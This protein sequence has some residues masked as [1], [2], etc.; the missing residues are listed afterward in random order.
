MRLLDTLGALPILA[1]YG[2]ILTVT[3]LVLLPLFLRLFILPRGFSIGH[4]SLTAIHN[5]RWLAPAPAGNPTARPEER[6]SVDVKKI[7]FARWGG[8]GPLAKAAAKVTR[9]KQPS[10][11]FVLRLDGVRVRVPKAFA[12]TPRPPKKAP[13][14]TRS[15]SASPPTSPSPSSRR[16]SISADSADADA[17]SRARASHPTFLH[18]LGRRLSC[19]FTL[20]AIQISFTVEVEDVAVIAG[21]ISAGGEVQHPAGSP[22]SGKEDDRESLAKA[23]VRLER[24]EVREMPRGLDRKFDGGS[25]NGA[26]TPLPA[27]E[28]PEGVVFKVE[29]PLVPPSS[30]T[31]GEGSNRWTVRPG[32][33]KVEIEFGGEEP[34][35]IAKGAVR[36]AKG[37]RREMKE[38]VKAA[39]AKTREKV[40]EKARGGAG[41]GETAPAGV[42]V[43]VHELKRVL[44]SIE[45]IALQRERQEARSAAEKGEPEERGR[46]PRAP[47][48]RTASAPYPPPSSKPPPLALLKSVSI[49]LPAFILS[50]HYTTP[51]HVVAASS[52]S[53][54]RSLPETMAFAF[55]IRGAKAEVR[56]G[57]ASDAER[58]RKEHREWLGKGRE[59]ACAAKLEWKELEGRV[60]LDGDEGEVLRNASKTLSIGPS[61]L[62]LTSTWLPSPLARA[63][64]P[65]PLHSLFGNPA[66]VDHSD[67]LLILEGFLGA[68]RGHVPF[69]TLDA[70]LR[71]FEARPRPV[72]ASR[73]RSNSAASEASTSPV[74]PASPTSPT[75]PTSPS[76]ASSDA[77]PK[78]PPQPTRASRPMKVHGL[79]RL[80]GN[81][82]SAGIEL[83]VQA[84]VPAASAVGSVHSPDPT[85]SPA[86]NG[87]P[88]DPFFRTWASPELLCVSLPR[89][90]IT[91]GGEYRER[92]VKRSEADRRAARRAAKHRRAES[93]ASARSASSSVRGGWDDEDDADERGGRGRS[94]STGRRGERDD[95]EVPVSPTK[96]FEDEFGVP[97][98][99]PIS[100][101]YGK[102]R[103]VPPRIPANLTKDLDTFGLEYS[104]HVR[105]SAET[106]NVY[107]LASNHGEHEDADYTDSEDG[108]DHDRHAMPALPSDPVRLDV[109]AIGP[110]EVSSSVK[111]LGDETHEPVKGFVPFVDL[112]ECS[113]DHAIL[114]ETI[115][116]DLWRPVVRGCIRDFLSSFAS[117]SSTATARRRAAS[118]APPP[119][120]PPARPPVALPLVDVLPQ[121]Q[122]IY[123]SLAAFD[124]RIAGTDP[125]A[126]E[127]ACRGIAAHSGPL[128]LEYLLQGSH[129]S[130][131]TGNFAERSA[132]DL[133]EDI[134]VEA[135]S[136]INPHA[137]HGRAAAPPPEKS[138]LFKLSLN[139]W[140]VDPV[141]DARASRGQR[142]SM[143]RGDGEGEEDGDDWELR[144]RAEMAEQSKRRKSIIPPRYD[145]RTAG[146]G[147]EKQ[148]ASS[149]VVIPHLALRVKVQRAPP[150][151]Y[152]QDSGDEPAS[153]SPIDEIIVNIESEVV[154]FRL[155]LFSI[156][157][158]LVAISSLRSL[159][160]KVQ[161]TSADKHRPPSRRPVRPPPLVRVRADIADVHAFP[162]L[163]HDTHL[164]LNL[165]R[166]RLNHSKELG[167]VCEFDSALLAGESPTVPDKWEDIIRLQQISLGVRPEP[168]NDG[169]QPFVV[170]LSAET[171]RLRIPF[172]Y[173]FSRII[174]NTANLI[175]ATKQLVHEHIKGGQG[176]ILEPAPEEAKRLPKID[177]NI[178]LLAVSFQDDPFETKLNIIWRAGYEEQSARLDRE[179]AFDNKVEAIR[180]RDAN[181]GEEEDDA[182]GTDDEES[183]FASRQTPKVD[184]RHSISVEEARRDLLAYNSSHWIKRIRNA[185]AEQAR[186]EEALT[187]QLYGAK[188]QNLRPDSRLPIELVPAS[189]S[190]PLARATFHRLSLVL[191]KPSFGDEG[192][193]DY[194]HDVGKG[195]PRD[196]QFT[197]LVP[198]HISC[199]MREA[200]FRLRDYP[201]PLLHV[202]PG[203]DPDHASWE[204]EA[205]LVIAEEVGGPESVR[206]V[207]C[208]VIPQHVFRGQGAPYSIVVPRSAMTVKTY[209]TPTITI[210]TEEPTRIGW[211]NSVQPAIQDLARV[212]DTL[213]K[214]S[215]DPSDRIG[216]WDKIRLQLHW[217]V[218]FRFEGPRASVIFHLKGSR[219][220]YALTGFGAGFAKAWKGNVQFR[221]GFDNPDHEFF[222]VLSEEYILGIP[223]LRDY[224]DAAATG[225]LAREVGADEDD[226][227]ARG[228]SI[229]ETYEGQSDNASVNDS[230]VDEE[231][232][233]WIKICAK[234][235]NGVRW[236]LGLKCE[237]TCRDECSKPGCRDQS[238][239]HRQCR[240]FDFI[241]H[242][243]V[244]T[245]TR[246]SIGPH[247]EVDDSFAGF[248]SDFVH[249]SISLT[250]PAT[251]DLP[252]RDGSSPDASA[253]YGGEHG[254]NSFHFTP[255]ANAHFARWWKTFD[256]TMSL[257]IRQGKL[258]PSAQAPSKKF[259]KH[260][261]TIKYRFSLAPLF[262]SHTYRQD[263][264]AEWGRGETT[265]LG[266]KGKI[267]R[268][269]VD[270]HQR[271]QEMSIRRPEM[272]ESKTVKHKA[273]YMAEI[274]LD[275]VDLRT[276]TALFQEPEKAYVAPV[277]GD[278]E[279]DATPP[280]SF[281]NFHV[282]DEDADWINLNDFNDA[283]Y[284]MA[285]RRPQLRLLPLM[286]CPRFTY[287]RHTDAA[288]VREGDDTSSDHVELM[289][290]DRGKTKFGHEGSHTCLMGCA[291]DTIGVQVKEAEM[292][293]AELELDMAPDQARAD[294]LNLRIRAVQ[295]IIERLERVR[296]ETQDSSRVDGDA[297]SPKQSSYGRSP[298]T[299]ASAYQP[300]PED[301][302]DPS[303]LPHLA[304]T[305]HE[306]WGNWENRYMVHN[307]TI[308]VSNATREV[309]LK[310]YY[311]SRDRK[312]H[313]YHV[314][315][316][317]IRFIR[318]LVKQHEHKY[319]RNMSRRKSTRV[320]GH[321]K[322]PTWDD[323]DAKNRLLDDLINREG[324]FWAKN[325]TEDG[326]EGW[327]RF[328][329]H[330]DVDPE[331]ASAALP[332]AF[333]ARTGHLCMFIKPQISLQSD[334]DEKSTLIITA[335]RAQLKVFEIVDTRILDDP[336][337]AEVLHQTFARLDGLQVFYPRQQGAFDDGRAHAFVPLETLVDLRVEP[338]G[339]DR[340]VPR[341][342]AAFRYD[343]FNQLRLSSKRSLGD[344]GLGPTSTL[345]SH[346]HTA[347]DRMSI[348]CEKF[349]LSA[350]PA[351]FAAIY[352][353]VT[354]LILYSDPG[355]KSRSTKLEA[356]VF[357]RD[358][359][360]L[361]S[362]IET[363]LTLQQRLR[364][365]SAL[366]QE[367]HVHLDELDD[368][369]RVEL[370]VVRADYVRLSAELGLVV[371]ALTRAQDSNGPK[372]TSKGPGTQL[373]ARAAEITWHMLDKTDLPFA[374]FSVI[375]AEF[376]WI[377][378]QD[379]SASNRLVVKDLRALNSS[380]DQIFAEIIAKHDVPDT[381]NEL[382]KVDV[383]AAALWNSLAPVG[384][385]SIVERFELH[386]HP[387]RLQLE[388]RIG[389][390]IVEY[391]FTEREQKSDEEEG[392]KPS[393]PLVPPASNSQA[394]RSVDSLAL[395]RGG[396]SQSTGALTSSSASIHSVEHRLRKTVSAE[397]LAP[398]AAEEGLDADE[399][400]RR[401]AAYRTFIF[402]E[403]SSTVLCLTY[404]SEKE[405]KSSLPNIYNITYKTPAIQYRSRT[406]SFLEL[407]NE[408]K[409]D[410][411]RSVWQQKGQLLGQLLSKAHRSLPLTDVRSAAKQRAVSAVRSRFSRHRDGSKRD[412]PLLAPP[413]SVTPSPPPSY[414]TRRRSDSSSSSGEEDE[415]LPFDIGAAELINPEV[416]DR[417]ASV[418]VSS[419]EAPFAAEPDEMSMFSGKG[420]GTATSASRSATMQSTASS[421]RQPS[422]RSQDSHSSSHHSH[423][424]IPSP[425]Y[426]HHEPIR[427]G[428]VQ[429][430]DDEKRRM[431][432]GKSA[433]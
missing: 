167:V 317:V 84:P 101:D 383:F 145:P 98:P 292:R 205:D 216:F 356:L 178:G 268:F 344:H 66:P 378:K 318:D 140:S 19:L 85:A 29:A 51:L 249:F 428:T 261:A 48:I 110:L 309:L 302:G 392:N 36:A 338:W 245:K 256:G 222:Q 371:E 150:V 162:T 255:H 153:P 120:S 77:P 106:L 324:S 152:E 258:F 422:E 380:P 151:A 44:R 181:G 372:T 149:L 381:D 424:A 214:P 144:G 123:V 52:L 210:R 343:K 213:S 419:T 126:D 186:R 12:L 104:T 267:G 81:F 203:H 71:I 112:S 83:R 272:S 367:Y 340:V 13:S 3:L 138:A 193:A 304:T 129:D 257:P 108:W 103:M 128:V 208:A 38:R 88:T 315:A 298:P 369:G 326:G 111:F 394:S 412:D 308:R 328:G 251:L 395:P 15:P 41:E 155:E 148:A 226:R 348:E 187:R 417:P 250:S 342:S 17:S 156:Y 310:Y 217:R 399:M 421:S 57:G 99:P 349:S 172:R 384:G 39:Q 331:S 235:I 294:E 95:D 339:F 137:T 312:G 58:V 75:S 154:T 404:R 174:D 330:L 215:P 347:T 182:G 11:W 252:G 289:P 132:L 313:V 429:L 195:F 68:V 142:R 171:A 211:G 18:R 141:V 385:I 28:M 76:S 69:E 293:L 224:V 93:K 72:G 299:P 160:P 322:N 281:D 31:S 49:S 243:Q 297:D 239:F 133:R 225:A 401:A 332:E 370:A 163:P 229:A 377:S 237:R 244:H 430:R 127:H 374:K 282:A 386:L 206:R 105:F 278:A 26:S 176:F 158:A 63:A 376:S 117:A 295:H 24:L 325:E 25:T 291:T 143:R 427:R 393:S 94:R 204:C 42:H 359:S 354:D 373:E 352:N 368:E 16:S 139:E 118:D 413:A 327:H 122:C 301:S 89:G 37:V 180:R 316:S 200:R 360:N 305:L 220:P 355:R 79:P 21:V 202:P 161:S 259:G 196:T 402:V 400:R 323:S 390:Q 59:L 198:L 406:W 9:K 10:A 362:V 136:N 91:F 56:M 82:A 121:D 410:T 227:S 169:Q 146:K 179:T 247:G 423:H 426:P 431:L 409:R 280:P 236:G 109:L 240:F 46:P 418:R 114:I 184:G 336:V 357:T 238:T 43:R 6:P 32:S 130:G 134:R 263:N 233:Y 311:S 277:D 279:E 50:A 246:A 23:W 157:L 54:D 420:P 350:N 230:D 1:F 116:V 351:H 391:L 271:E 131:I 14:P 219:D 173:I 115:G 286:T 55:T 78:H 166:L 242:W 119:S 366:A 35:D 379:G 387:V 415:P 411:I 65:P 34:E 27:L 433:D 296:E 159:K 189:K 287:Y 47:P 20:F 253:E 22:P 375:G 207:P 53:T 248:R 33:V 334:V 396:P 7:R 346:F 341:T 329:D 74:S 398:E 269:N 262:I 337:N 307:P 303:H 221:I 321:R 170:A 92:S 234:C 306:E 223:N 432:L 30:S 358:F 218:H 190:V 266:L 164:F 5:F 168:G 407:L 345:E 284:T 320:G 425:A 45:A 363:V 231:S 265:V 254:Y 177:I 60:K 405:D 300:E 389:R 147:P 414:A 241:P 107:I 188:H 8:G 285:D 283:A 113:G 197:L 40:R 274:D 100:G 125:K 97:P 260:C 314:S 388:H 319:D 90:Q 264:W 2:A 270:L 365:L 276:I 80:I 4:L 73:S 416:E 185:A 397:V 175:K 194:L 62:D 364:A 135:N 273:F 408:L 403:I 124:L 86:M 333:D 335:F 201:L 382:A 353:V 199:R 209:M 183:R 228:A 165:R 212:I 87:D 102:R 191:S 288:P 64:Y 96:A 232:N 61:R 275:S 67:S 70:S 290:R 361:N 192:L